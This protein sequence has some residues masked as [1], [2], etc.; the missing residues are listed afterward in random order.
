MKPE[1]V[2]IGGGLSGSEAAWQA[3]ERGIKVL[4]Y[5]MRPGKM[6]EAHKTGDLAELVCSNSLKSSAMTNAH[7]LLKEELRMLNSIILT[8]ADKNRV[9][10]GS[11]LAVDRSAFSRMVSD[12]IASHPNIRV[13]R[14]EVSMPSFEIPAI[15]ATGPLTSEKMSNALSE[16]I[17]EDFIYFYDAISPIIS[18]DSINEDVTFRASRYNKSGG[19]Y[20][21][22]PLNKEEYEQFYQALVSADKTVARCFEKAAYFEGC[23]PVEA[24]AERGRDTLLFGPMKPVGLKNPADDREPYAVIQLRQEDTHGQAFNMV[25]FQTRLRWPE[26]KKVFRL[27]PGLENAEF[28]RY[29]SLHRNTYVNSPRLLDTSLRLK[30]RENV[31]LTGQ[32]TG[33]EGY[34]ESTAMGI[35]AGL[36]S[37]M[38]IRGEEFVPPP[39]TTCI[40][41][42]LNYITADG[43]SGFQPMNINWGLIPPLQKK[44]RDRDQNRIKLGERSFRDI[45]KWK[46]QIK[47]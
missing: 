3:A 39:A 25:G 45:E 10:A 16:I 43:V 29:G 23:M 32:L 33:V 2:I 42:L 11:A 24:M 27:I 17:E 36:S 14:E 47:I 38:H 31:Y 35:V 26:Q 46:K 7:G 37:V 4:L 22:C 28:L 18:S 20:I 12:H 9:P 5:E 8:L 19:D 34:T 13:I 40:G 21:N 6:T 30:K 41:A 44:I 15:I 1:L